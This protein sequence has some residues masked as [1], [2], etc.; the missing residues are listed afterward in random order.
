MNPGPS[1][2]A[3]LNPSGKIA[4]KSKLWAVGGGKGGIGKSVVS[5]NLAYWLTKFRQNVVLVDADLGGANLHTLLG[6]KYVKHT[7]ADYLNKRVKSLDEIA[8][9]TAIKGLRLICGASDIVGLANPNY[10]RK[11]KLLKALQGLEA[12]HLILDLGAGTDY[13]T[14][15]FF[16]SCAYKIVVITP[17][18]T[19]MQNGYGFIKSA[20][21]R[22]IRRTFA[23]NTMLMPLIDRATDHNNEKVISSINELIDAFAQVSPEHATKLKDIINDFHLYLIVNL[24]KSERDRNAT[25][26]IKTVV[27]KYLNLERV[28]L[29]GA[30]PYDPQIET[31][32]GR[33]KPAL[34]SGTD[35][36]SALGFYELV[37]NLIKHGDQLENELLNIA[38]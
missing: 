14:L 31:A 20:L 12:D 27:Q 9:P 25:A 5:L 28:G 13:N 10:M 21:F 4:L 8:I 18:P 37:Y 17:Q 15:D 30:I 7:L 6:I 38:P 2:I 22:S 24:V 11:Q 33:M 26:V 16:L 35:R 32:I 19:S 23:N 29:L 3:P 36:Q 34:M 1:E